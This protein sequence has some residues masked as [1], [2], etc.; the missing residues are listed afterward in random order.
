MEALS[1]LEADYTY[2]QHKIPTGVRSLGLS[3]YSSDMSAFTDRF[4]RSLEKAVVEQVFDLE[5][6]DR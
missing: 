6:A 1:N 5:V 4:D 3:I 2:K